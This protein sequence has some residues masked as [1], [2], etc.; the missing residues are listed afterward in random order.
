MLPVGVA[1]STSPSPAKVPPK[2][3]T[4][5][6]DR[7]GLS[8]SVTVMAGDSVVVLPWVKAMVAATLLRLGG[9][10]AMST[11]VVTGPLRLNEPEP[12][13]STQVTV[14]V[15]LAPKLFG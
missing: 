12:S 8:R 10:F 14:R 3:F 7:F 6:L 1:L 5:A 11:V 9:T 13:L 2:I 4:V 15:L